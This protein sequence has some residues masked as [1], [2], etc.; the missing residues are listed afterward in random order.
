M[1][2]AKRILF[3]ITKASW[4]GAQRYVY[5]LAL[6]AR[7]AQYEVAVAYG[8]PGELADR[9]KLEKIE[10]YEIAGLGRDVHFLKDMQAFNSLCSTIR[11][12][13]PDIVHVNSSKIGGLGAL[14]ARMCGVEN[15][16]FTAHA[17]A[18]NEERPWYQKKSIALLAW[19]TVLLAKKTIV[20]SHAMRRQVSMWPF[21]QEKLH[22]IHNGVRSED[23]LERMTA[24]EALTQLCPALE[25]SN[26]ETDIWV[27]TV[28]ELH[29]VKGLPYAINA[30]GN[31]CAEY[32]SLRYLILSDGQMR[33]Q[34]EEL[35]AEKNLQKHVFLLGHVKDA[36]LYAKAYD[37]F[38]LPSLSES[39]GI[40]VL[41]AG[42][43]EL[44]VIATRVGG[45]PEI[46]ENGTTGILVP[47]KDSGALEKALISLL[48]NVELR[49][50]LGKQL[51]SKVA[52][53]FSIE[54]MVG[55]TL[56]LYA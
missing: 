17:W 9:L 51:R 54:R 40:A 7:E 1:D 10:I 20:V 4:G 16:I 34:L 41:E 31:L 19:L 15:I 22:V 8:T 38:L 43:A 49:E 45:L 5:D 42:L 14:A 46:I 52:R 39:F 13:H 21:V 47:P 23:F 29:P 28:G 26:I 44:P 55:E 30:V 24:R 32:P 37:I 50:K 35:I 12:F 11:Y 3:V 6:A 33:Q 56:E 36:P 48:R 2:K 53:E 18:F 25:V 27:S